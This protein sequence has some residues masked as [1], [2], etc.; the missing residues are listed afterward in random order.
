MISSG[1]L[2]EYNAVSIA[3]NPLT[4][5]GVCR[6]SDLFFQSSVFK[7]FMVRGSLGGAVMHGVPV[8]RIVAI[9]QD[10]ELVMADRREPTTPSHAAMTG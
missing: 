6:Y 8:R 3:I 9:D 2:P 1:V 7:A 4:M 5:A 10:A